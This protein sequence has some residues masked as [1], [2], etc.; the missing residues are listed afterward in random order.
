MFAAMSASEVCI[1]RNLLQN[2]VQVSGSRRDPLQIFL[3]EHS[4]RIYLMLSF[5]H[6]HQTQSNTAKTVTPKAT[7]V[8][9]NQSKFTSTVHA[10]SGRCPSIAIIFFSAT[11]AH[12]FTS[13]A[14][15][16]RHHDEPAGKVTARYLPNACRNSFL[17]DSTSRSV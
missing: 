5:K 4:P 2:R 6:A 3:I 7:N 1:T 13:R 9:M 14:D 15:N 16:A 12:D 17:A 10:P 11:C 8:S